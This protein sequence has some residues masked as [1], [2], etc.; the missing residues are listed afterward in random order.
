MNKDFDIIRATL[1]ALKTDYI[2]GCQNGVI[3]P[4]MPITERDIVSEIYYRL[5]DFCKANNLQMH[6]EVKPAT[7]DKMAPAQLKMLP[8]IDVSILTDKNGKS[9]LT[10]AIKL[11]DKYN[12]GAI[13]ARFSSVPVDFFHTAI[14]AKIQSNIRDAQKDIDFL[15]KIHND[16]PSC[17]CFFVLLNARG[18]RSD[19]H[20]IA[21][22]AEKSGICVIEYSCK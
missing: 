8:R 4:S 22:Y 13:E 6:C 9:W 10:S 16:N 5:I 7:D 12:K 17:N 19:H 3:D 15:T 1:T 21:A 14:E 18:Q 2:S 20:D 11:Q